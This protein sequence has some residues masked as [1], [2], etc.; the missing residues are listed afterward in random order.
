MWYAT[1]VRHWEGYVRRHGT[2]SRKPSKTQ[3]RKPTRPKRGTAPKPARNR[4]LALS[5]DTEIARLARELVEAREEQAATRDIL[6]V[7]SSSP[8]DVQPVFDTIAA[9]VLRLCGAAFSVVVRFDGNL[10]ELASIHKMSDP[11]GIEALR[12]AFPRLPHP[13]GATDRAILTRAVAHIPDICEDPNY[14]HHGLAQATRYRS[15]LSVPMLREGQPVGAITVAR[16][17]PGAFPQ[18]QV[19][20]LETF[21]AQAVIAIENTRLLN[22][23]RESLQQQTATADVLQVISSSPGGLE[24]VFQA[25]LENAVRVC[26]AKFGNLFLI[27]GDG[28][29]WTAGVGNPPFV[30]YYTQRTPFRPTPGSHL[31]RV[32]RTKQLSHTADDTGEAVVGASARLGGARSTVCVPMLKHD[33]LVGAIFIYR[34]E[35]RPFTDKQIALL[36]NFAAQAVIAIENIRLL[37]ELR[38][39]LQQQTATADVLKVISRST[40]DLETVLQTLVESAA[41]LCEAE[42]GTITR[43]RGDAFYRVKAYGFSQEFM[44][45]RL[46]RSAG[47]PMAARCWKAR[48]FISMTC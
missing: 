32:M 6:R 7:I 46:G 31:D 20:L 45:F 4:R 26:E 33:T 22:E 1:V 30:E 43:K 3:H 44:I 21:A 34:T 28:C 39:S 17:L 23:L 25:M 11:T 48:S 40:F 14:E 19:H 29:R 37:N 38:E 13:G 9:N 18:R 36:Q 12:R 2:V 8:T 16:A 5:K 41:Q 42:K 47:P 27:D 35:V 24:P 10:I 15:I